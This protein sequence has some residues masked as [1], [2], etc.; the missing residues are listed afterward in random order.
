V[1]RRRD[2]VEREMGGEGQTRSRQDRNYKNHELCDCRTI[3]L[4]RLEAWLE[5]HAG[6][7]VLRRAANVIQARASS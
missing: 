5:T 6:D 7:V 3:R 4:A 1:G 2:G